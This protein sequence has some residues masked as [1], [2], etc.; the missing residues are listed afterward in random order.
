MEALFRDVDAW[1]MNIVLK[2]LVLMGKIR[3][4][5]TLESGI[6]V[7]NVLEIEGGEKDE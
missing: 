3:V 7:Y 4:E 6:T 2:T 1:T 5:E